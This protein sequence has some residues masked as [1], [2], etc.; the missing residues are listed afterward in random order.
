[1]FGNKV[2][3]KI[4]GPKRDEATA[5]WRKLHDEELND[6]YASPNILRVI[7]KSRRMRWVGHVEC[8][9][10]RRD[11]YVVLVGENLRERDHL[12]TPGVDG[13]IILKWMF[14]KWDGE[15]RTR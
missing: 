5:E 6:L 12:E 11:A 13:R 14:K 15:A 9:G 2:L 3:R 8:M 7:I 10:D 4:F 1:M